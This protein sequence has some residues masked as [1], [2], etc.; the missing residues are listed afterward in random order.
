MEARLAEAGNETEGPKDRNTRLTPVV[1]DR[2]G[3]HRRELLRVENPN[4]CSDERTLLPLTFSN[5]QPPS[6]LTQRMEARLA[7]VG[8]DTLCMM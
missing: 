8:D 4:D 1:L 2:D 5:A 6:A 3:D 7:E